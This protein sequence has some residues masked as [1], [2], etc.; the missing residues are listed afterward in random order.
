MAKTAENVANVPV[1]KLK[2]TPER[3]I[4]EIRSLR[5]GGLFVGNMEFVDKLL[6]EYDRVVAENNEFGKRDVVL[7][8]DYEQVIEERNDLEEKLYYTQSSDEAYDELV[9]G[10]EE[11]QESR[12]YEGLAPEPSVVQEGVPS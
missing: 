10:T 1:Q 6:T 8:S 4:A 9:Q 12:A 5:A 11:P 3:A 2:L 7:R